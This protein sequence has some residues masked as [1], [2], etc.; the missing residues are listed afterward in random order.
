MQRLNHHHL[1][2][3]WTF[4]KNES[5]TKTARALGIAQSAVTSQI[6]QLEEVLALPLVD[7]TH[8]R[9]PTLTPEGRK[10]LEYADTIFESS[11]ELIQWAT[12]GGLP[13]ERVIR[14]GALSGLSRNFQFEF[15]RPHLKNPDVRYEFITGDQKNLV[16]RLLSH[17]L[18]VV[19]SSRPPGDEVGPGFLV[20]VL[21]DSPVVFV[22]RK[23]GT[24]SRSRS[25]EHRI[26]SGELFIPGRSFEARPELDA[27]LE[28]M[29][30]NFRIKGEVEDI[31][32]LRILALR[33]DAVVAVPRLG[34]QNDIDSGELTVLAVAPEI[35]Q[36]F[37]A[38]TRSLL[39]PSSEVRQL[40]EAA[41]GRKERKRN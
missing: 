2:L 27:Y 28:S 6:R 10:V 26:R 36:R 35:K 38:I 20:H 24:R 41:K 37:Y 13:K 21:V 4:G 25:V 15:I 8:P 30:G 17:E 9:R 31:A 19:L 5:F 3:Y 32:L 39:N 7:R 29:G 11:R 1:Y 34:V 18:D 22:V 40:I 12:K 14:I 33:S 23:G 16:S